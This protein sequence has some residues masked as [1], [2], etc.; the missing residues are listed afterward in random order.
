VR[1]LVLSA[2]A[3]GLA[4]SV[5]ALAPFSRPRSPRKEV[6]TAKVLRTV[7]W[8]EVLASGHVASS[9]STEIRCTLERLSGPG[10]GGG[11]STGGASTILSLI[12][13][14]STV[15]KGD[16]LCELDASDYEELVRRQKILVKQTKA[17]HRQAALTSDVAQIE[18]EAYRAGETL[19]AEQQFRGQ[20]ALARS[21]L[22]RQDDRLRWSKRM[23]AKGYSS[24]LQVSGDEQAL[25]RATFNLS[26]L[27][28]AFR[29]YQRFS[30]PK[31][32]L[33]LKSQV[34]GAKATLD[35][36]SIRLNQEEERLAHYQGMVDR[37]TVRAPHDGFVI[38]ANRP[39]RAPSV[40]LGAPVRERLRLFYL[41]DLSKMEVGVLLHET[42]VDRVR[43]GMAARVRLEALPGRT[44]EGRL[45]SVSE[46]P[47][48]DKKSETGSEVTYYL[49]QVEL[50]T[51]PEGLRPGMS[52]EVAIAAGQRLEVLA[53]PPAA[54]TVEG[55]QD[56]CY[57]ARQEHLERRPVKVGQ[58]TPS[59]LEV[60]EG[61]EEDEE[62]VL[63]PAL[64]H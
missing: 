54:V 61:L 57:V 21:A 39:D 22:V 10:Q 27:I 28:T 6:P 15:K 8:A 50:T 25:R 5:P 51:Q 26:Q 29:N 14:G 41:P 59:L 45:T 33:F 11:P 52:A 58:S 60:I 56:I 12:P 37:C 38:Y 40:Y 17:D 42:V 32:L 23:V 4:A 24:T 1:G 49:G 53:V 63:D 35:F 55:G 16:V 18:L 20:I 7:L 13:D 48:T 43:A 30:A 64:V 19:Q 3:A 36:Q 62:V 9:N 31:D 46:L 2:L 44:L 47:L 34:I